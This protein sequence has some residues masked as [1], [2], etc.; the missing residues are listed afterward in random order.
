MKT[1]I[2]YFKHGSLTGLSLFMQRKGTQTERHARMMSLGVLC[3]SLAACLYAVPA[4][5]RAL[6]VCFGDDEVV[7]AVALVAVAVVAFITAMLLLVLLLC[8]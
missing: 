1:D 3:E 8:C 6:D 4:L 5:Q 7:V 2:I